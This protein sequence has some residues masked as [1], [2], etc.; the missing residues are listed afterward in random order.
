MSDEQEDLVEDVVNIQSAEAESTEDPFDYSDDDLFE[1]EVTEDTEVLTSKTSIE[2]IARGKE[3][4]DLLG[5]LEEDSTSIIEEPDSFSE[6]PE[7]T[8][9]SISTTAVENINNNYPVLVSTSK[10]ARPAKLVLR[11]DKPV[12]IGR[13]P[14]SGY[15]L[16]AP[17]VSRSHCQVTYLGNNQVEILDVSSNG[18]GYS[19]GTIESGRSLLCTEE[20]EVLHFGSGLAVALCFD[21][22]TENSFLANDG[23]VDT[24]IVEAERKEPGRISIGGSSDAGEA[25]EETT[26]VGGFKS[27]YK[28]LRGGEED[29]KISSI[30]SKFSKLK[31]KNKLIFFVL[32]LVVLFIFI[33]LINIIFLFL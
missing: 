9:P 13:D 18:T 25:V 33:I 20:P 32:A 6:L 26:T 10:L 24:F 27:T 15:W 4:V 2:D 11:L 1:E 29:P 30:M 23:K 22:A 16:G 3:S 28:P 8:A 5:Q 12:I 7:T 19:R 17:F 14:S 31:L 21:Q